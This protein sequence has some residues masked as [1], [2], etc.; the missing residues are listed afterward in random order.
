LKTVWRAQRA[1]RL[2]GSGGGLSLVRVGLRVRRRTNLICEVP[3]STC[4]RACR[5]AV[6]YSV[7]EREQ[8]NSKAQVPDPCT[9]THTRVESARFKETG[10]ESAVAHYFGWLACMLSVPVPLTSA[11][12]QTCAAPIMRPAA[13]HQLTSYFNLNRSC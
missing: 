1:A 6:L 2:A 3:T 10:L 4:W 9:D 13:S 12:Y 7:C 11:Q 5:R 8:S